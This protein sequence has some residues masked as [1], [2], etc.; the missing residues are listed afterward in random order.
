MALASGP[1]QIGVFGR[2]P[3]GQGGKTRLAADVGPARAAALARAFLGDVLERALLVAPRSAWWWIAAEAGR[4][5]GDLVAAAAPLAPAGI[6]LAVQDGAHLGVAMEH[7]LAT[8]LGHGPAL[9][10]GADAPDAPLA[11]MIHA[12]ELLAGDEPA[13]RR[14]RLVLG[15]ASDGG[16]WLVGADRPPAGLLAGRPEWGGA[17]VL[18]RTRADAEAAAPPWDVRTIETWS[19]V[20][21][22]KDLAALRARLG[23]AR[24]RGDAA[25]PGWPARTAALVLAAGGA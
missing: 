4:P 15:P 2:L 9:L 16:F 11:A 13:G 25:R 8:M 24:A 18:E 17:S 14:P 5:A 23:S 12:R 7:A 19:D 20:D 21:T 6:H 22:G 10:V 1:V 3:G